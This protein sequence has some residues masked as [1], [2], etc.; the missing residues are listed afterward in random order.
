MPGV[1]DCRPRVLAIARERAKGLRRAHPRTGARAIAKKSRGKGR[2]VG[3]RRQVRIISQRLRTIRGYLEARRE[4][5]FW[6]DS[7]RSPRK[8][9]GYLHLYSAPTNLL[10]AGVGRMAEMGSA[11]FAATEA[12]APPL[13]N[14]HARSPFRSR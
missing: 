13:R 1:A 9:R 5:L 4:R 2:T 3:E 8:G 14:N 6:G 12:A 11:W 7:C 10:R